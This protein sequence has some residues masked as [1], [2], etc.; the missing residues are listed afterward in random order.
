MTGGTRRTG[1]G[2]RQTYKVHQELDG[3]KIDVFWSTGP[4]T[5]TAAYQRC[6]FGASSCA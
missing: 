3:E 2:R 4:A 6:L 1:S 5:N